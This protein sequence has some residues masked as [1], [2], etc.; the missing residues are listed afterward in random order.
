MGT[1]VTKHRP[2]SGPQSSELCSGLLLLPEPAWKEAEGLFPTPPPI[3]ILASHQNTACKV[4]TIRALIN[5]SPGEASM[6]LRA[7]LPPPE[8]KLPHN[9]AGIS[10][11]AGPKFFNFLQT[12]PH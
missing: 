3:P 4:Q 8:M 10:A 11:C 1:A 2:A 5:K 7:E 12:A 9:Q 6:D